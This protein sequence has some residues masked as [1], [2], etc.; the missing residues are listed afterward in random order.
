MRPVLGLGLLA[1]GALFIYG[2]ITGRLA[3]M[4]AALFQP[5]FLTSSGGSTQGPYTPSVKAPGPIPGTLE[6]PSINNA[7]GFLGGIPGLGSWN[8][9]G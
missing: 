8:P 7:F 9:F 6:A 1:G 4:L 3:P 5:A 2:G